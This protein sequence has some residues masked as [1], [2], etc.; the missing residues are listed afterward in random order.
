MRAEETERQAAERRVKRGLLWR[1]AFMLVGLAAF[2]WLSSQL[3]A[4]RLYTITQAPSYVPM[5]VINYWLD[6]GI[7]IGI[8]LVLVV[9]TVIYGLRGAQASRLLEAR[10][11]PVPPPESSVLPPP[12]P[13]LRS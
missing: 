11:Y 1:V 3:N 10:N 9:E 7:V 6:S 5:Y 2:G 12:P 13:N 8:L 4:M